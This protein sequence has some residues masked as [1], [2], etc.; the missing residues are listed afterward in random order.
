MSGVSKMK[1]KDNC[2][3][4]DITDNCSNCG[5]QYI[6]YNFDQQECD[7]YDNL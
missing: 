3:K 1:D 5:Y 6:C 7:Y 2:K 4:D